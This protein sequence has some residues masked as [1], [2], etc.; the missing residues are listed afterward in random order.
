M[1]KLLFRLKIEKDLLR[2]RRKGLIR[3]KGDGEI[4]LTEKGKN[5]MRSHYGQLIED[6]PRQ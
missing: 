5:W 2:L 3:S 6:Y 1:K 4:E